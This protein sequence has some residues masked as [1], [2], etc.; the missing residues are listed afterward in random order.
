VVCFRQRKDADS[1]EGTTQFRQPAKQRHQTNRGE[2]GDQSHASSL[3]PAAPAAP[4][5][6]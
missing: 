2:R 6:V 5:G 4:A 3:A 1:G